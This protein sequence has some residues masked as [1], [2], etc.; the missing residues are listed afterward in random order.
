MHAFLKMS[1]FLEVSLA[2][3][4][5]LAQGLVS[6]LVCIRVA[7]LFYFRWAKNSFPLDLRTKKPLLALLLKADSFRYL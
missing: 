7:N 3:E 6:L 4:T 5:S 1:V 2:A